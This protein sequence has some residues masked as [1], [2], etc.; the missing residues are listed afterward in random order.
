LFQAVS[1]KKT[2][3]DYHKSVFEEKITHLQQNHDALIAKNDALSAEIERLRNELR[4]A[5]HRNAVLNQKVS[6]SERT[7]E[8]ANQSKKTMSQQIIAFQKAE[9]EWS[10]LEREMREELVMLR[11]GEVCTL[12]RVGSTTLQW[13]E[14]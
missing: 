1:A 5:N 9:A 2:S 10:K 3:E 12:L 7:V 4:D 14:T 8:A 6:E 13:K 11:K